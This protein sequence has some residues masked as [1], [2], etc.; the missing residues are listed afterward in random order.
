MYHNALVTDQLQLYTWGKNLEKQLGKESARCDLPTPT[1]LEL[2]DKISHVECGADFTVVMTDTYIVK[3]FGNNNYGQCGRELST[4]NDRSSIAGKMVRLR[5][6]KRVVRLPDNSQCVDHPM[7]VPLPRPKIRMNF[8]AVR[9]LKSVPKFRRSYMSRAIFDL[10]SQSHIF[11]DDE[12]GNCES[13]YGRDHKNFEYNSVGSDS[14]SANSEPVEDRDQW[15]MSCGFI[16]YCL[17]IFHGI[18]DPHK[19]LQQTDLNEFKIRILMLNYCVKEAFSLCLSAAKATVQTKLSPIRKQR[20]SVDK[21]FCALADREKLSDCVVKLFEFFTKNASFVPIH[22]TDLKYLIYAIFMYFINNSMPLD[23][24]ESY[25]LSNIDH[26]LFGLAII[27]FFNNNNNA[28]NS[29]LERQIQQKYAHLF[30]DC[31]VEKGAHNLHLISG[32]ETENSC[33]SDDI[34]DTSLPPQTA[35][36]HNGNDLMMDSEEIF[37]NVST[38]FKTI[39]C[40]R[41]IEFD[42]DLN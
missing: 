21:D 31:A 14:M 33:L 35:Q 41:L 32:T 38:S 40:Q 24:I 26:Y 30:N 5:V 17:F 7:E 20:K 25:F 28:V 37:K 4:A 36:I 13:P 12:D 34:S 23:P 39:I 3:A 10:T 11:D 16:H 19:V 8:E 1:L 9:Y 15:E 2:N 27:F 6:S 29:K 42:N 22:R 18:Y